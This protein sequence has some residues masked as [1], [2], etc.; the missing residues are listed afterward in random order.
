MRH[1]DYVAKVRIAAEKGEFLAVVSPAGRSD[2]SLRFEAMLLTHLADKAY[3]APRL[4]RT[5]AGRPWHRSTAG[6]AVL[7]SVWVKGG[8]V[9]S[10]LRLHGCDGLYVCDG[11]VV[12]S[13][14]GVNPQLTI[15]C[16]STLLA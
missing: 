4:V 3:L 14:I 1:G 10:D 7:V 15:M 12:P 13:S 5:R 11:S 9:D 16:L 6:A 2:A 8:V